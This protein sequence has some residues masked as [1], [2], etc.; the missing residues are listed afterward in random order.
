M[1]LWAVRPPRFVPLGDHERFHFGLEPRKFLQVSTKRTRLF[2][3]HLRFLEVLVPAHEVERQLFLLTPEHQP[4]GKSFAMCAMTAFGI[5]HGAAGERRTADFCL[6]ISPQDAASRGA[7]QFAVSFEAPNDGCVRLLL[8]QRL[9]IELAKLFAAGVLRAWLEPARIHFVPYFPEWN[10]R[11]AI[12]TVLCCLE[13]EV[14]PGRVIF[15]RALPLIVGNSV[16]HL[17]HVRNGHDWLRTDYANEIHASIKISPVAAQFAFFALFKDARE[18]IVHAEP[19]EA[20]FL[21]LL[22]RGILVIRHAATLAQT[23][24]SIG[25]ASEFLCRIDG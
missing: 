14:F 17:R 18:D 20:P 19:F 13:T 8:S 2:H 5:L 7:V 6:R 15:R 3:D 10:P 12:Q 4:A 11:T 23:D 16:K 21:E 24:N 25:H 22:C 1:I 9:R